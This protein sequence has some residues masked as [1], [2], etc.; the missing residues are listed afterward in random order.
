MILKNS[1]IAYLK[2]LKRLALASASLQLVVLVTLSAGLSSCQHGPR[3]NGCL[4][5][6]EG[7]GC[8]KGLIT[9]DKADQYQCLSL[10]HARALLRACRQH[11]GLPEGLNYCIIDGA[12]KVAGCSDGEVVDLS[13]LLNW[14]CLSPYDN[15]RFLEWCRRNQ[16]EGG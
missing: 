5:S 11:N 15:N 13:V 3:V 9:F 14:F 1:M 8:K 12:N 16:S 7:L 2:R 10:G 6:E 4:V